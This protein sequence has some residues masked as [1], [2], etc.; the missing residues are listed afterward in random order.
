[1]TG[2]ELIKAAD[3]TAEEIADIISEQCPPVVPV[4]CDR[5]SCRECWLS[6]LMTGAPPME[7]GPSKEQTAPG[8]E[9]VHPNLAELYRKYFSKERRIGEILRDSL[10]Q[11]SFS[12][13]RELGS[14]H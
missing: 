3:T 2:I 7:K 6:W 5:L 8:E 11:D 10:P 9:G 12:R 13:K 14:D 4:E 1:M